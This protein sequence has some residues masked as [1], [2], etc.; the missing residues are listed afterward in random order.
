MGENLIVEQFWDDYYERSGE[1]NTQIA[2]KKLM[3]N[4]RQSLDTSSKTANAIDKHL[5]LEEVIV[6][7]KE[8]EYFE[9][10]ET[11]SFA[12]KHLD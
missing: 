6:R 7:A 3:W 8:E 9:L 12:I 1:R 10:A 2:L 5:P 4:F 11:I